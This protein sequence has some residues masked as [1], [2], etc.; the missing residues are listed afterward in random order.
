MKFCAGV[1]LRA[2]L[3][4]R[5][6]PSNTFLQ[7]SAEWLNWPCPIE[8]TLKR[9][10]HIGAG[11]QFFFHNVLLHCIISTKLETY[12]AMFILLD[13][14]TVCKYYRVVGQCAYFLNKKG[15]IRIKGIVVGFQIKIQKMV[16]LY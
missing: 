9:T 6:Q 16:F 14:Q 4:N 11:F 1:L 8:S 2:E 13:F 7:Q 12:F 3:S 10:S 5:A 15:I